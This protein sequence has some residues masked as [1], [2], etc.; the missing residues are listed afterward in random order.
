MKHNLYD[1]GL[2]LISFMKTIYIYKPKDPKRSKSE[3]S[4]QYYPYD[5][6]LHLISFM[7]TIY[8]YK[9]KDPKGSKSEKSKQY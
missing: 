9:P 2:Y 3:K 1:M 7:K 4:K 8:I 5:M 6:G